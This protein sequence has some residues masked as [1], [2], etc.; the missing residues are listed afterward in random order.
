MPGPD[1]SVVIASHNRRLRLLWQLNSLEEQSIG[2]ERF[3]VIVVHDYPDE[4][5][6]GI[7]DRHPL[8]TAGVLR[9]IRIEPGTGNPARQRNLGWRAARAPLV[10]F[11]DD[12]CRTDPR[13]LDGLLAASAA[14]PGAIVQGRTLDDPLEVEIF[15]AP[16]IRTVTV[17]DP[18]NEFLQT[19][20]I[21]YPRELLE[22]LGGFDEALPA[23]AGED[24]DLALRALELGASVTGAPDAQVWHAVEEYALPAMVRLGWKWQ[25]VP[26]LARRH[27]Q[28]RQGWTLGVFWKPQH[29]TL[30]L[31]LLGVTLS[32]RTPLALAAA[33]PYLN[34]R[35]RRRGRAKRQLVLAAAEL[36]GQFAVDL[37]ELVTMLAGS[38]RYRTVVL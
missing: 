30:A 29:A 3:E 16:H 32:R 34:D 9:Q 24:T 27:P 14:R 17:P 35:L 19:C 15:A 12:D 28:V 21:L 26:Y 13:W 1:V 6:A 4:V 23:P 25:H 2:L 5:A 36:P 31:A 22:R 38:A 33:A 37:A 18:P 8:A 7:I 10:A 20:N 11:T